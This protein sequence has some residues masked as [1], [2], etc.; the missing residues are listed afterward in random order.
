[1]P[2]GWVSTSAAA[3]ILNRHPRIVR[4]YFAA[5]LAG[6][7]ERGIPLGVRWFDGRGGRGGRVMMA[8]GE[9]VEALAQALG[10][11][12][13]APP[14][15]RLPAAI[16]P[17]RATTAPATAPVPLDARMGTT[18]PGAAVP[19]A[20]PSGRL[21]H[22]DHWAAIL[23]D[24][25]GHE[26]GSPAW[27][28]AIAAAA[29]KTWTTPAGTAK[30]YKEDTIRKK[31][32]AWYRNGDAALLRKTRSDAGK[33][34]VRYGKGLG[35]LGLAPASEDACIA[36]A[37]AYRDSYFRSDPHPTIPKATRLIVAK[38]VR[39][40][41]ANGAAGTNA[42]LKALCRPCERFVKEGLPFTMAGR[43]EQ[44]HK[45]W[46]DRDVR[47]TR[48][49]RGSLW[50]GH[51]CVDVTK[52]DVPLNLDGRAITPYSINWFD[53]ATHE[54]FYSTHVLPEGGAIAQTHVH[55]S[56]LDLV[57][58]RGLPLSIQHD[59]GGEFGRLALVCD[60]LQLNMKVTSL[61][62]SASMAASLAERIGPIHVTLPHNA[63]AKPAEP[64]QRVFGY[65]L[66]QRPPVALSHDMRGRMVPPAHSR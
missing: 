4:K 13:A 49:T 26:K 30:R 12:D 54:L 66:R 5:D 60:A 37:A 27:N 14:A 6:R 57:E 58:E 11:A 53:L 46:R 52:D 32:R 63:A 41:R 9:R 19:M 3:G 15:A 61:S 20:D 59:R 34:R 21:A 2:E 48:R 40:V 56:F 43:Y 51:Y 47:R 18:E 24:I 38:M 29:E 25:S 55:L 28:A 65:P 17:L 36:A 35:A 7:P 8:P 45:A 22:K 31:L 33:K 10:S 44:D 64:L 1:M 23:R 42:E 50:P 62:C 39:L 16:A